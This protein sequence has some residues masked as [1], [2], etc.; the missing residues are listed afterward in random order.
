VWDNSIEKRREREEGERRERKS[1]ETIK[2]ENHIHTIQASE[3]REGYIYVCGL[4]QK[5]QFMLT[6]I[7]ATLTELK[8]G[9][10]NCVNYLSQISF[11]DYCA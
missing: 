10:F 6:S 1:Q 8:R 7:S 2:R 9:F 3:K 11:P 4:R 5:N